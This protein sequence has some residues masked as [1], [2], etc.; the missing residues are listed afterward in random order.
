[1]ANEKGKN[2]IYFF[3][4]ITKWRKLIFIN[5]LLLAI[6]AVLISMLL[7]KWY[8]ASALILPPADQQGAGGLTSFLSNLPLSSLGIGSPS[9]SEQTYIA[10]LKSRTLATDVIHKYKLKNFYETNTIEETLENFYADYDVQ[11]T[12]ENMIAVSFEYTDSVKV[13]E[14]VNYIVKRLGELSTNL[15]LQR[16]INSKEFI[17]IR[18]IQSVK[19]L[20][21]LANEL[22]SFQKKYG[23]IEFSE[24]T[25]AVINSAAEI[26]AQIFLKT[27]ELESIKKTYG[28]KNPRY[29]ELDNQ[30][31]SLKE[32]LN[33]IK[34]QKT[35]PGDSPF[36]SLFIPVSDFPEL[37]KKYTKL[38]SDF[39]LQT[40]LQEFLLPQYEQA[41]LQV[42]KDKPSL[43]VIDSAVPA[44]KKSKPKR[45]LI[46]I[47]ILSVGLILNLLVILALENVSTLKSQHPERYSQIATILKKWRNPFS[48]K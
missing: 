34:F 22:E 7:P 5:T 6:L 38:Y 46:V 14:I 27:A 33:E 45:A 21:S 3:T 24:Q 32:Q 39:V 8:T 2:L 11:F 30:L 16:A 10:I 4:L 26:E 48:N 28:S 23:I 29:S 41:K 40:K 37:A 43:Q 44:D 18:Y 12:E 20:D 15:A 36:S 31:S 42:M 9:G 47:G 35:S 25:K 1:M 13:A 17:E 19:D